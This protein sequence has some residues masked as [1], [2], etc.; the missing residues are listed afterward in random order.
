MTAASPNTP[1]SADALQSSGAHTKGPWFV[2]PVNAWVEIPGQ[3]APICALLWPTD[4]RS[5]GETFANGRL[6]SASPEL[7]AE[8]IALRR[9]FHSACRAGGSDDEIVL[10]STPGADAAI[11]KALGK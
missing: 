11:A 4:L 1:P 9:R 10:L 2:N 8:L 5:E 3:D 7:L 6:I